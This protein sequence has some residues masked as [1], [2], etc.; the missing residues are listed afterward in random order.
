MHFYDTCEIVLIRP[1]EEL[2]HFSRI[3]LGASL[4]VDTMFFYQRLLCIRQHQLEKFCWFNMSIA[5][6]LR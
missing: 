6:F 2:N 1:H 5:F 3:S 4:M